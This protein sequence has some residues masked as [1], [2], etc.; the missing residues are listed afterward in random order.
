M[1]TA[2]LEK[3]LT[4]LVN[5]KE[6]SKVKDLY[7]LLWNDAIW[8]QAYQNIYSNRGAFTKGVNSDTLDN[9]NKS[10]ICKIIT[11]IKDKSYKPNPVRRVYIP[12]SNGKNRP[13]GIP[14]GDDKL[15]QEVCRIILEAIYESKFSEHSHGFRPNKSCHSAF[16]DIYYNWTGTK[17]F[18]EFDI[19]GCFDNINHKKLMEILRERINDEKFLSV[20]KKFLDAGY[21]EDWKFNRT[22]S[23]TPQGGI[24]SPI[25]TNIYLNKLDKYIENKCELLN[26][27]PNN[28]K[29]NPEY[30]KIIDRLRLC[31][32]KI[33]IVKNDIKWIDQ[34]ASKELKTVLQNENDRNIITECIELRLIHPRPKNLIRTLESKLHPL[35]QKYALNRDELLF[36]TKHKLF[37]NEYNLILKELNILPKKL[38]TLKCDLLDSGLNRLRYVRY[39][40]DFILGFIGTKKQAKIIFKD[41]EHYLKQ[42]LYLDISPEKSGIENKKGILFLGYKIEMPEYT[43]NRINYDREGA[44]I[45]RRRPIN[46]PVF[47][48]THDTAIKFVNKNGYGDYVGN[49]SRHRPTLVNLDEVEIV[50]QYNAELRGLFNYYKYTINCKDIINKIAWLSNYSLLKTLAAKHKCGVKDVFKRSILRV[51]KHPKTGKAWYIPVGEDKK[52]Y[53]FMLKDV[54]TEKIQDLPDNHICNDKIT[55]IAINIRSSALKKLM[56]DKCEI[57]GKSSS[58]INIEQ[59]HINPVR[60]I[61]NTDPLW[62]KIYKLR[63]R[64]IL[65]VCHDCHMKIHHGK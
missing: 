56:A 57:C 37:I 14:S 33:E 42:E 19:K 55:K 2:N 21:L 18:I 12:K 45:N 36:A 59:H 62:K 13:L 60:N 3:R 23:G 30:T 44:Q 38:R 28:R 24:I 20:I 27:T 63:Q 46:K 64:K 39:A 48:I 11:S 50:N 29:Q 26:R 17:W 61:P 10:R 47:K 22:I 9:F 5:A 49:L 52:V 58:E 15:V 4:S 16:K 51:E 53:V 35:M 34:Y 40:D 7:T 6:N 31:R 65:A 25:L 1:N 41:I 8:Y 43:D 32:N 54:E